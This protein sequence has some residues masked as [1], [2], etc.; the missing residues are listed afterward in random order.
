MRVL[1]PDQVDALVGTSLGASDWRMVTQEDV[2]AF[3]DV[4]GDHQFIHTD[5]ER[6]AHGPFG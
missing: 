6:A 2:N 4:T 5:P 3:A 1:A